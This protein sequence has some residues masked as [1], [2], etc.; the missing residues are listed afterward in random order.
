[1]QHNG[2]FKIIDFGFSKELKME[3]AAQGTTL[4]TITTMAPEVA[5]KQ[6]YNLKVA[7]TLTQADIWSVGAMLYF[8]LFGRFPFDSLVRGTL[9]R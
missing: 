8:M 9:I 6:D 2:M 1:M 4:G 5:R 3:I 7:T